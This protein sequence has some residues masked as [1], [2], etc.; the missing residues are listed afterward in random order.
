MFIQ[1]RRIHHDDQTR[2]H[3]LRGDDEVDGFV[4]GVAAVFRAS[5]RAV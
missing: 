1:L 2:L 3:S 5:E 4:G